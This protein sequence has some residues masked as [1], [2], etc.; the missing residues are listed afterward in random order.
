MHSLKRLL[1]DTSSEASEKCG[2][3]RKKKKKGE[4]PKRRTSPPQPTEFVTKNFREEEAWGS[5]GTLKETVNRPALSQ[6][7]GA[8]KRVHRER[9]RAVLGQGLLFFCAPRG[10]QKKEQQIQKKTQK[11]K[12]SAGLVWR[13]DPENQKMGG[14]GVSVR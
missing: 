7:I 10:T 6:R 4:K 3:K 1:E 2:G 14:G 5:L 11:K 13:D 12:E 9:D 8:G